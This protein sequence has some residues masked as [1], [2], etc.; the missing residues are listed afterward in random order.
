M[1][2][3][4]GRK[5]EDPIER[6]TQSRRLRNQKRATNGMRGNGKVVWAGL[7]FWFWVWSGV[8]FGLIDFGIVGVGTIFP[9]SSCLFPEGFHCTGF[10]E[11]DGQEGLMV[12]CFG[13]WSFGKFGK[14][15]R[16]KRGCVGKAS[17]LWTF[18]F[19]FFV[20]SLLVCDQVRS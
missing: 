11:A 7:W 17:R 13:I 3:S 15:Q 4:Q 20:Y 10:N 2:I 6:G 16:E 9:D 14:S 1:R 12:D 8:W 19:F 18:F 5:D